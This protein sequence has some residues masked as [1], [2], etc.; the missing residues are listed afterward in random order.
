MTGVLVAITDYTLTLV[1]F[2]FVSIIFKAI[3]FS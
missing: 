3:T 2:F 1:V